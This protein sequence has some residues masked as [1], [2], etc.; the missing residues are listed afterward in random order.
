MD[1]MADDESDSD[2]YNTE[3][4]QHKK[5]YYMNKLEYENVDA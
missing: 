2:I 1:L 5:D 4:E 3:F